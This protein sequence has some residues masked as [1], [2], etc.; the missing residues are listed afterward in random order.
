MKRRIKS[1]GHDGEFL[2]DSYAMLARV[3]AENAMLYEMR[4][5]G[6]LRV[7]D[8]DIFWTTYYDG[9]QNKWYYTINSYGVYVGKRK[10]KEYEGWSQGKLIPRVIRQPISKP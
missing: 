10:A 6:Y 5:K 9:V 8:I 1:F 7:L 3:S 2:D 4:G